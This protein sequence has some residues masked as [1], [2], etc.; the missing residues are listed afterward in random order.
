[1]T[2]ILSGRRLETLLTNSKENIQQINERLQARESALPLDD[3]TAVTIAERDQE[4]DHI[5]EKLDPEEQEIISTMISYSGPLPPPDYL[6]GY[7][8]VYAE[9]PEKIFGWV[10]EQTK[11]RQLIEK[12]YLNKKF[13]YNSMGM[14]FGFLISVL[15]IAGGFTLIMLDKEAI[16]IGLM[17]PIIVT[18]VGLLITQ[19]KD[20]SK[21]NDEKEGIESSEDVE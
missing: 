16:G 17:T 14:I 4:V 18:L 3:E 7:A 21:N 9:A 11:H 2:G 19:K 20:T 5:L 12:D 1:M 8:E 10:E 6:K 13:K 15:F